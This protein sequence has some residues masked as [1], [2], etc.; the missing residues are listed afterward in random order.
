MKQFI[1]KYRV[2]III[3]IALG[4]ISTILPKQ[5]DSGTDTVTIDPTPG[6]VALSTESIINKFQ[7]AGLPVKN[8][9]DTT[10]NCKYEI[11]CSS[12]ITTDD[13]SVIKFDDTKSAEAYSSV[14]KDDA[15]RLDE[16]V[17]SYA[18]SRTPDDN[19]TRYESALQQLIP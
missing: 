1:I 9:R 14:Y 8:P 2:I 13:I 16:Y 7:E 6:T 5:I 17:L 10:R 3:I 12:R 4:A 15:Y 19:R 11:K 18:A